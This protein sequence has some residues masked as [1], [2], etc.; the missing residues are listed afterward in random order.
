MRNSGFVCLRRDDHELLECQAA[1]GV[2]T[3][4]ENVL[5]YKVSGWSILET[6]LLQGTGRT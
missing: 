2:G 6:A 3:T 5:D 4:V 1:T